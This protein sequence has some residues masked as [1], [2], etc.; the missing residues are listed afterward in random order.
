MSLL[1]SPKWGASG[2]LWTPSSRLPN[3]GPTSTREA[4]SHHGRRRKIQSFL[5][6]G[7]G[8]QSPTHTST[9]PIVSV[10]ALPRDYCLKITESMKIFQRGL[11]SMFSLCCE[12]CFPEQESQHSCV[13][14]SWLLIL[15]FPRWRPSQSCPCDAI[16]AR[17]AASVLGC[18]F[19]SAERPG[20]Q[21]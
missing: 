10:L 15:G 8:S 16:P 19:C 3:T 20:L 21:K 13:W 6:G 2:T 12:P 1:F 5:S 14:I 18:G 9:T 17:G 7:G 4:P 11:Y